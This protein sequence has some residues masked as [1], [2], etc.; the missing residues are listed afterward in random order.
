MTFRSCPLMRT[1]YGAQHRCQDNNRRL[2]LA[3]KEE[4]LDVQRRRRPY[5][6]R[7]EEIDIGGN[8]YVGI[9]SRADSCYRYKSLRHR[10]RKKA[11][12]YAD[13]VAQRLR[14]GR[15]R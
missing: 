14:E 9:W 10:D 2:S 3:P 8:L 15:R 13:Q 7:I 1:H 4:A 5:T 12:D 6:V 11:M